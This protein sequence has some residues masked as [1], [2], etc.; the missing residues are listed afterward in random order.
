MRDST[1]CGR[2]REAAQQIV[3]DRSAQPKSCENSGI[4]LS[5]ELL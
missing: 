1:E 4:S 5:A 3:N 2:G